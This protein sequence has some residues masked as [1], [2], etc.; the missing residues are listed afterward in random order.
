MARPQVEVAM[1][2]VGV[3]HVT[4]IR[5][6]NSVSPSCRTVVLELSVIIMFV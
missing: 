5:L 2:K 3:K 1:L 4:L 6:F